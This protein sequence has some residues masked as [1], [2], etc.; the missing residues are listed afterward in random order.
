MEMKIAPM[1]IVIVTIFFASPTLSVNQ[2][3]E[4]DFLI[5]RSWGGNGS[6]VEV[7]RLSNLRTGPDVV[8]LKP[9][10]RKTKTAHRVLS[11]SHDHKGQ[12]H[13]W[14]IAVCQLSF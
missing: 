8:N 1:T 10:F 13:Q 6:W 2:K 12:L 11:R 3:K 9:N 4:N 7:V 5:M 14:R